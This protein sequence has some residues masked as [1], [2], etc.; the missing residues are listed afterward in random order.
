MVRKRKE[1]NEKPFDLILMDMF[2]PVMD[3]MEAASKINAMNTGTP[4]IAMTANV[5]VSELEKYKKNG[6]PD[7]LGKPFTTQELWHI[8]LKYL[9][10]INS[11]P[12]NTNPDEYNDNE[13]YQKML[14]L[15]FYRNN[16]TVYNEITEA[17]ASGD[18]KLAH[19]LAHT[20][21]G[22]AGLLGKTRLRNAASE[23][24]YLLRDGAASVWETKMNTLKIELS[25]V[26]DEFKLLMEETTREKPQALNTEQTLA[27]FEKLIPMLENDN[28]ECVELLGSIRAVS[29]TETLVQQI[30]DYN[31]KEAARLAAETLVYLKEKIEEVS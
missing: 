2:M 23:I 22:N 29:G 10:P 24:E 27:L 25:I 28:P 3:G 30:E 31:F 15:N 9:T 1:N 6:M 20:L 7:C 13:E 11:E 5:M 14:R 16:Q 12:I 4:I 26:L 19:R 17:V 21:K 18:T 8:L